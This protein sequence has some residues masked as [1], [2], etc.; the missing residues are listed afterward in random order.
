MKFSVMKKDLS[1]DQTEKNNV[2][3]GTIVRRNNIKNF[4]LMSCH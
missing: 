1:D 4:P 2:L 3:A